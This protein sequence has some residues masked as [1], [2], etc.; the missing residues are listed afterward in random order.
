MAATRTP[1]ST[2]CKV[3]APGE[4]PSIPLGGLRITPKAAAADT[5]GEL[6]LLEIEAT[7]G[8]GSPLHICHFE[9]KVFYVLDGEFSIRLN[10]ETVAGGPGTCAHVPRGAV[11]AFTNVGTA[12]GRL[13]VMLTPAGHEKFL[14]AMSRLE[15]RGAT[16]PGHPADHVTDLCDTHG[17]ELL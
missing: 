11:H 5:G 6:T 14:V 3:V 15:A 9:S 4:R 8:A 2:A 12:P 16:R 10:G 17:V 13:L 7:P 1:R